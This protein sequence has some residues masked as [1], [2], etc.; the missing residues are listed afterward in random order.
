LKNKNE[1][2]NPFSKVS[3]EKEWNAVTNHRNVGIKSESLPLQFHT[4]NENSIMEGLGNRSP[5]PKKYGTG[6]GTSDP[7]GL[8]YIKEVTVTSSQ[9]LLKFI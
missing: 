6:K 4:Q 8:A 5:L 7:Q 9:L 2:F 1:D 3:G